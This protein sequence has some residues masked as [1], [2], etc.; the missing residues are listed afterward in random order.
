MGN[1]HSGDQQGASGA[2]CLRSACGIPDLR[3]WAA[4]RHDSQGCSEIQAARG[5][6]GPARRGTLVWRVR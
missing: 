5:M 4:L 6:M 2:L 1:G 3:N